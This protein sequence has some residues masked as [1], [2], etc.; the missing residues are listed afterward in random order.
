MVCPRLSRTLV[1]LLAGVSLGGISMAAA[2]PQRDADPV[3]GRIRTITELARDWTRPILTTSDR[4]GRP[5]AGSRLSAL[6]SLSGGSHK[7]CATP[8]ML[9]LWQNTGRLNQ[10]TRLGLE[11]V[12]FVPHGSG[13]AVLPSPDGA[14]LIHY[15][16][17]V[18]SRDFVDP[19]DGD[20]DG[21]PDGVERIASE[22][23]DLLGDFIHQLGWPP[24]A[25]RS[26]R[27]VDVFLVGMSD[28]PAAPIAG[29]AL[30]V[31]A[32]SPAGGPAIVAS[33]GADSLLYL[34]ARLAAGSAASKAAVA[35]QLAHMVL[36][37]ESSREAAWWH[38]ASATWIEN[39]L[40][41]NAAAAAAGFDDAAIQPAL[42]LALDQLVLGH[43]A[44]LWPHYL[45]LSSLSD[46][47]L[48]RRIWQE[49]SAVPGG[50]TM[51]A[52]DRVLREQLGTSLAE[53]LSAF[54]IWN[55]F[56]GQ[57]D[58]GQHYPFGDH[59]PTPPGDAIYDQF[60]ARGGA[61]SGPLSPSGSALIRLLGDGSP[62]GLRLQF[63]G[64]ASGL[65][66]VGL[67]VYSA[68]EPGV[69]R[70]VPV[71]VDDTGRARTSIPWRR[72]AVVDLL[73]QN[74]AAAGQPP[75]DYTFSIDYDLTV[76]FDMLHLSVDETDSGAL[77]SWSTE[78]EDRLAGWH[79]YR[80]A[81]PLGPF[82]RITPWLLPGAGDASQPSSYLFMDSSAEPGRRHYYQVEGMT[83]DGFGET[84]LPAGVRLA[85]RALQPAEER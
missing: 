85:P 71:E 20:L 6:S 46:A 56:V 63:D 64:A 42:G 82:T 29:F 73:V 57:A 1:S 60:P 76:P 50:N 16:N 68:T 51:E 21:A 84:T 66:S 17:D 81:S 14:F 5:A 53:E 43:E 3:R 15:S 78:S 4:T 38:E 48:L 59:L 74:L 2:P 9:S 37:R 77:L 41:G 69:L 45:S 33:E 36:T 62:G 83:L 12:T 8:L 28:D 55:L 13:S 18:S 40:M 32:D 7:G 67:I 39:R 25:A 11:S 80:G 22:L 72:L 61:P 75:A 58:D 34:D 70:M 19:F 26:G 31:A 35:H 49:L 24:A 27:P 47:M 79:V 23:T 30:P 65:W 52:M 54:H 44:F 10:A